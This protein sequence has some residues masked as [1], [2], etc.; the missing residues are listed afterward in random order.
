MVNISSSLHSLFAGVPSSFGSSRSVLPWLPL[1]R[2]LSAASRYIHHRATTHQLVALDLASKPPGSSHI[3]TMDEDTA[4][5]VED[6]QNTLKTLVS[7][8]RKRETTLEHENE[9]LKN[10][11]QKLK[12]KIEQL[13]SDYHTTKDM[14]RPLRQ[15]LTSSAH[16]CTQA[17]L[18]LTEIKRQNDELDADNKRLK[19]ERVEQTSLVDFLLENCKGVLVAEATKQAE[20]LMLT[21]KRIADLQSR[22]EVFKTK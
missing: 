5:G 2:S 16:K 21:R 12:T 11:N 10:E 3:A 1:P 6:L 14:L 20:T 22:I 9:Q 13:E 7:R 8:K 15:R 18:E 4:K 17:Y 19:N